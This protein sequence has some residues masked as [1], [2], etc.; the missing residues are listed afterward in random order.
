[1]QPDHFEREVARPGKF[2]AAEKQGR[3]LA[4]SSICFVEVSSG[5]KNCK[6]T[7]SYVGHF[8]CDRREI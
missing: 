1:M 5:A 7:R 8:K 6:K 4:G 3:L 2:L